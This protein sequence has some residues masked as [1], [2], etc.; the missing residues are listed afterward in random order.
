MADFT[1]PLALGL[2]PEQ[3][4]TFAFSAMLAIRQR[5]PQF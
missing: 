2:A 3:P 1:A 5:Q 4:K